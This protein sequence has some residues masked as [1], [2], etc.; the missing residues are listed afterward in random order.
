MPLCSKCTHHPA[1]SGQRWCKSCHA[2]YMRTNRRTLGKLKV[3]KAER[4]ASDV[5]RERVIDLFEKLGERE[6]NGRTAAELVRSQI[7]S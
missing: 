4:E 2:E 3:A 6:L 1:K 7:Y 5:M